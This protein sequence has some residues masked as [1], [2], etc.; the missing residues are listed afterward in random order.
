MDIF[1]IIEKIS[2]ESI[3]I[4]KTFS[5]IEKASGIS[6]PEDL[7]E[8]LRD[9][10][11]N[12]ND[13]KY[14][15]VEILPLDESNK[16]YNIFNEIKYHKEENGVNFIPIEAVGNGDYVGVMDTGEICVYNHENHKVKKVADTWT[17]YLEM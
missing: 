4:D 15:G 5:K 6:L 11:K 2:M 1:Q 7:K 17:K 9:Y 14:D 8:Y 10:R 13:S 16:N 12:F 3:D